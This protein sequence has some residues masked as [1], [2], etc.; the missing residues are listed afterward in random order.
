[1]T[2]EKSVSVGIAMG[3]H[4]HYAGLG[5]FFKPIEGTVLIVDHSCPP[6]NGTL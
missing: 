1:M 4:I 5:F 6:T 3:L 2:K